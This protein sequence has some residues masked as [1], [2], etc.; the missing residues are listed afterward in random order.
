MDMKEDFLRLLDNGE[1]I[2]T[3]N[4]YTVSLEFEFE[5][6]AENL[7]ENNWVGFWWTQRFGIL[8]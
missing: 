8:A 7:D 1:Q 3:A 2:V 4:I 5:F 6:G